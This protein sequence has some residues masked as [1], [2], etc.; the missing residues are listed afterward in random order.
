M[1]VKQRWSAPD[2]RFVLDAVDG[3][4]MCGGDCGHG[5]KFG[6]LIGELVADLAEGRPLPPETERFRLEGRLAQ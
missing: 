1:A 4:I 3:V 6:A 2:D 5:F